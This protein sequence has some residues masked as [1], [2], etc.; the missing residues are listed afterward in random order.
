MARSH[1][2]MASH[3]PP[4]AARSK[5]RSFALVVGIFL[6]LVVIALAT[7]WSAIMLVN[8][9]RAYTT[10]EGRYSNAQKM[11]VL[12][13]YRYA[14][15]ENPAYYEAFLA[16]IKVPIGDHVARLA[17]S[18]SPPDI[19]AAKRGFLQGRNHPRDIPSL[20][21]LFRTASWWTPFA[22]AI[23]D[24][25]QAD[26]LIEELILE[27]LRLHTSISEG[28]LDGVTRARALTRIAALDAAISQRER[29]FSDH[30][31][32]AA[33]MA[34]SMVVWGLGLSTVVLWTI[35]IAFAV[36][37]L[38]RQLA[39]DR[40]LSASERRFRDYAEIASD[41]YWEMDQYNR[42]SFLSNRLVQI[43]GPSLGDAFGLSGTDVI[44]DYA[45]DSEHRDQCLEAIARREPY[46]GL[47]LGF[48]AEDGTK[49]YYAFSGKPN[50]S[51]TGEFLGYR[52]VGTDITSQVTDAHLL[53]ES[54]E[55]AE[56]ANRAKSEFLANMSHELRTPLNAI[57]GFSDIIRHRLFGADAVAKYSGYA[58]DIHESGSHLLAIINDILDLSK[59]EAGRST[60]EECDAD[61]AVLAHEARILLGEQITQSRVA[62][63]IALPANMPLLRVDERKLVQILVN[64]LSN[65]FKFTP[66]GGKITLSAACAGDGSATITVSDTGIGI[67][68]GDL[69]TVIAP[70]GQVESVFS[71]KHH[72][73]G[74][75]VPLAKSLAEL[76]GG[77]LTIES[78]QNVG[79]AVTIH[80]PPERVI[81][82]YAPGTQRA[83][84]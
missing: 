23:E 79:T 36:A 24:W 6:V 66:A 74:L 39:L 72:G 38:R 44:R 51:E 22:A 67:A 75:G 46:R 43:L 12:D 49:K 82:A 45:E 62:F 64:L 40:Q 59:I 63:E 57:L 78:T 19:E 68:P 16:D 41:W 26:E 25:R 20:I 21:A 83:A 77:A 73:T 71:R 27:G 81:C 56:V 70:F 84:R 11:A 28:R 50:V 48:V 65:A 18:Q 61:L 76:H 2:K 37:I 80:L 34:T 14:H 33:R 10:G 55:R 60:M 4:N 47:C 8:A 7:S 54:K 32:E 30:L 31:A 52:G 35:G 9:A 69:E 15:S 13:L 42:V 1:S 5:R 17:L 29:T 3:E 58:A 53:R